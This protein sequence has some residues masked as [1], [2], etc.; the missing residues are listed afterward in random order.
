M[1]LYLE[2][3]E[4]CFNGGVK[5]LY[6]KTLHRLNMSFICGLVFATNSFAADRMWDLKAQGIVLK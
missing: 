5:I 4:S 2:I 6:F 3:S 1:V